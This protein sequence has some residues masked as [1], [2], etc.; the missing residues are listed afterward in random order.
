M[1][2]EAE[3]IVVHQLHIPLPKHKNAKPL[4]EPQEGL[5]GSYI[6]LTGWLNND[7]LCYLSD[8]EGQ[9][10]HLSGANQYLVSIGSDSGVV[11]LVPRYR[12]SSSVRDL[13]FTAMCP[14]VEGFI[15]TYEVKPGDIITL[16]QVGHNKGI[17]E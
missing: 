3:N 16:H 4:P 2:I 14:D 8:E 15:M 7:K 17:G 5:N 10:Y 6:F 1:Q 11:A 9:L 12:Y 13:V